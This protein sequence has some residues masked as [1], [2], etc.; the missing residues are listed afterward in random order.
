MWTWIRKSFLW[1]R[2][3]RE[4]DRFFTCYSCIKGIVWLLVF[5]GNPF[6]FLW[7]GSDLK[8]F[9]PVRCCAART[10]PCMRKRQ[11]RRWQKGWRALLLGVRGYGWPAGCRGAGPSRQ[12]HVRSGLGVRSGPCCW[13]RRRAEAGPES[14]NS[15]LLE[16]SASAWSPVREDQKN[17]IQ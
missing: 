7:V 3:R 9:I 4:V 16:V 10:W 11:S 5:P 17:K 15:A 1:D 8:V 12:G 6:S 2:I 13:A 14:G